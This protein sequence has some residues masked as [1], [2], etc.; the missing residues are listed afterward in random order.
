MSIY[1]DAISSGT[2]LAVSTLTI[3]HTCAGDS[4][5]LVVGV[6]NYTIGGA[7]TV[8]SVTYNGT[9][10]T[11]LG[12]GQNKVEMRINIFY[13]F[14]PDLGTHDIV[15]TWSGLTTEVGGVGASYTGCRQDQPMD[16]GGFISQSTGTSFNIPFSSIVSNSLLFNFLGAYNQADI[17]PETGFTER[18]DL[19]TLTKKFEYADI[20][21]NPISSVTCGA[22]SIG[23]DNAALGIVAIEPKVHNVFQMVGRPTA[24]SGISVSDSFRG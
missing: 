20:I 2:D 21:V 16:N 7:K 14:A 24:D 10:M 5:L 9:S 18:V 17:V 6:F 13:L 3:S 22:S 15:I 19:S 23:N 1:R 8:N 12:T 4:R 11:Q